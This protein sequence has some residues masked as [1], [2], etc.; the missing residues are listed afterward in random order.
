MTTGPWPY[1]SKMKRVRWYK[2]FAQWWTPE[3]T[4]NAV[5]VGMFIGLTA[6]YLLAPWRG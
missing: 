4:L 3:R 2:R 1:N 5:L 6:I